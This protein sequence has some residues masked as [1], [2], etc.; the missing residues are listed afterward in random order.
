MYENKNVKHYLCKKEILKQ[1]TA[2]IS[3]VTTEWKQCRSAHG[4]RHSGFR[5]LHKCPI[6]VVHIKNSGTHTCT[7]TI[8]I[9]QNEECKRQCVFYYVTDSY[10]IYYN[11]ILFSQF[12]TKAPC[13]TLSNLEVGI[14]Y[15]C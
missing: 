7:D 12:R 5:Q 10:G 4:D 8:N 2:H 1:V 14:E 13:E 11:Y 6:H 9:F 3:L 15:V